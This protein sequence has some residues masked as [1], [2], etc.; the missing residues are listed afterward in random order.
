MENQKS[1]IAAALAKAQSA[2]IQPKK[3]KTVTVYPKTAKPY[4]FTY[5]DYSE[6]VE[7][8]RGPLNSNGIAFTHTLEFVG[9]EGPRMILVTRLIHAES[10]QEIKS[11]WPMTSSDDPKEVGG[12]MTYGKRYSLSSIT[13]CVADDDVDVDP[14]NTTQFGDRGSFENDL[15]DPARQPSKPP[16]TKPAGTSPIK[17]GAPAAKPPELSGPQFTRLWTI[18]SASGY[19]NPEVHELILSQWGYTTAKSLTRAQYDEL[20]AHLE[21]N[22]KAPQ[23]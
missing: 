22:P 3:N 19:S 14:K 21:A 16:V 8:V 9:N 1:A 23:I 12:D 15:P 10:G 7:A 11:V 13:G 20:I 2:F 5:A 4:S 17:I 18:A 6:I